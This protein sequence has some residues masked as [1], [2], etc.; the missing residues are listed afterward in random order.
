MFIARNSYSKAIKSIIFYQQGINNIMNTLTTLIPAAYVFK[1]KYIY[2][3]QS[4]KN[5]KSKK[6]INI[7]LI[8]VTS[9]ISWQYFSLTITRLKFSIKKVLEVISQM[10]TNHRQ[11]SQ[12]DGYSKFKNTSFFNV[13]QSNSNAL[14]IKSAL[15]L[16]TKNNHEKALLIKKKH[17]L[18]LQKE[19]LKQNCN[20]FQIYIL[21]KLLVRKLTMLQQV[22]NISAV[23]IKKIYRLFWIVFT[24]N[25]E[26]NTLINSSVM[27]TNAK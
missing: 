21:S 27:N 24:I 4:D 23:D 13:T 15:A 18:R 5:K 3:N 8:S 2:I 7:L 14:L 9:S 17:D 6:N 10:G 11:I 1:K 26:N 16:I 12:N 22:I 20:F 25:I 19:K